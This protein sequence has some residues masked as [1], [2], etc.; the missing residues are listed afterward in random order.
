MDK[1]ALIITPT[2][3]DMYF[4]DAYDKNNHWRHVRPNRT[5]ETLV[6]VFNDYQPEEGTYDHL[7][8]MPGRKWNLIPEVCKV[9][10]TSIYDYIGCWD[11]DY[12]TDI[13]SVELALSVA[14]HFDFPYFQQSLT[15]WTVYPCLEH[16]PEFFFTETNFTELGVPFFRK[17]IFQRVLDFLEDYKY[18]ESD[19]GIDKILSTYLE[20]NPFVFHGS[21]IKHM[22]RESTYSKEAGFREMNYLMY[23]FFPRYM[24][25][26][27]GRDIDTSIL[28]QQKILTAWSKNV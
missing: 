3:T 28:D 27:F 24:K 7:I 2:G 22:R 21:T 14:R 15:S 13:P 19:W 12:A 20:C 10:D 16:R 18:E 23:D 25:E 8:R 5:F 11:D 6:V 1:K 4:D 9:F 26:R 17:D